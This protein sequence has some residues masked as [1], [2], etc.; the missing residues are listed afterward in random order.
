[1]EDVTSTS[2]SVGTSLLAMMYFKEDSSQLFILRELLVSLVLTPENLII[3]QHV[4]AGVA[5][6]SFI[7][8]AE[9]LAVMTASYFVFNLGYI[10]ELQASL[11]LGKTRFNVRSVG[12]GRYIRDIA[13]SY[14]AYSQYK[15]RSTTETEKL[16]VVDFPTRAMRA[17]ITS[18]ISN[19][20][21]VNTFVTRELK[22]S[23]Y[24]N[25]RFLHTFCNIHPHDSL[26]W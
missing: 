5:I 26:S 3:E 4:L 20:V 10:P 7:S 25:E 1:M 6:D 17:N 14:S 2:M 12:D 15:G 23:G 8:L 24:L 18:A 21:A 13:D 9:G 16:F 11:D 22:K 19:R